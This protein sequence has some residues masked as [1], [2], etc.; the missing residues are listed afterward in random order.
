MDESGAIRLQK[1]LAQEGV[2]SRRACEEL[3]T[4]GRVRVNGKPAGLGMKIDPEKDRVTVDG[5]SVRPEAADY[6]YLMLNKPRGY[7]T[8]TK[9]EKDRPVVTQLLGDVGRRIYPVG[10]LDFN[11]EGLLLFTNDGAFTYRLT[12]PKNRTEKGYEV[13]VSKKVSPEQLSRLQKPL[14][15]TGKPPPPQRR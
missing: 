14:H 1:F 4:E 10:R 12:H 8:T 3:I 5:R 9:D 6:V 7:V 13:T 2:A 11:S 15:W